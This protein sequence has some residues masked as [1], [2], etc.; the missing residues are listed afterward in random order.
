MV[1]V[2]LIPLCHG[3][4]FEGSANP[5][6]SMNKSKKQR[7]KGKETILP[8]FEGCHDKGDLLSGAELELML[9]ARAGNGF[10]L[11]SDKENVALVEE[12]KIYQQSNRFDFSNEPGAHMIEIK[13]DPYILESIENIP[14]EI[15]TAQASVL[16]ATKA[17]GIL[18]S[19]FAVVPF[20]SEKDCRANIISARKDDDY[21]VRPR[22]LMDGIRDIM[23]ESASAYPVMNTAVHWTHGVKSKRHAFEMSRMQAALLPFLLV[24]TENRPPYQNN[25][26]TRVK[27]HTGIDYRRSLAFNGGID[28]KR[29]LIPEFT[30]AARDENEFVERLVD[31]VL[32]S[33]MIFYFDNDDNFTIA[34]KGLYLSPMDMKGYGHE[35]VAQFEQAL[36][37]FWWS[38]KYKLGDKPSDAFLH[39]LR[40]FDSGPEVVTNISLIGGMLALNDEARAEMFT[41]LE[42]KYGIPIMSDPLEARTIIKSNLDGA[43]HRGDKKY[44]TTDRHMEVPFGS[45][46]HTMLDFLRSDLLPML[47]DQYRNMPAAHDLQDLRF[48]ASTGMTNTQLWYDCFKSMKQ[49]ICAV[50]ELVGNENYNMLANQSKSW[51]QH[52]DEGNMPFMKPRRTR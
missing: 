34:P 47:E 49:Q 27:V 6:G 4:E 21:S 24:L 16:R 31:T 10:R 18:Q 42:G 19:P 17:T 33:P 9:F 48:K 39:E 40:D 13:T 44:H 26:T 36:S 35:N 3:T 8:Y 30:Y 32:E 29:G 14:R 12:M 25:D 22:M 38:F 41:R 20:S 46:G 1:S 52:F 51:A 43:Y 2:G 15:L 45:K 28:S 5:M 7:L 23:N 50:R 11:A 37:G